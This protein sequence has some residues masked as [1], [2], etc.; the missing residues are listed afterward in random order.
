[1]TDEEVRGVCAEFFRP[2]GQSVLSLGP[3]RV[4]G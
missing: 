1:V 4:D 3:R 2:D